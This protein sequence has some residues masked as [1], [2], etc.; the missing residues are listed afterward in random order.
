[1]SNRIQIFRMNSESIALA[2]ERLLLA[3]RLDSDIY[4]CR[5]TWHERTVNSPGQKKGGRRQKQER[6]A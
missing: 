3:R 6:E 4:G 5:V 2:F 1:M